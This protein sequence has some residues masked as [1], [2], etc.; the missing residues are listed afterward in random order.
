MRGGT[1]KGARGHAHRSHSHVRRHGRGTAAAARRQ[2]GGAYGF[3]SASGIG[4][5]D[6][7]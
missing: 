3:W 7:I 1:S 6:R 2:P 5:V 4:H